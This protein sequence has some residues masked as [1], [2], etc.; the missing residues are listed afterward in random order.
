MGGVARGLRKGLVGLGFWLTVGIVGSSSAF[1]SDVVHVRFS[2]KLKGE[3]APLFVAQDQGY[4]TQSGLD[5]SLGEGA[6]AQ[7]ALGALLQGQEDV[8]V[9]PGIYALL[10][11]SRGMPIKLIA[12]YQPKAPI[13]YISYPA[14]P[15]LVPKDLEG[16]RIATSVGDTPTE[17]LEVLCKLNKI[18]CGTIKRIQVN[19]QARTAQFQA[20][21]VD[22]LG[23]YSN[24]DLPMIEKSLGKNF[25]QMDVTKYGLIVPGLAFVT[26]DRAIATKSDVLRRFLAATA[27]GF[28]YTAHDP[29]AAAKDLMSKWSAAPSDDVVIKQIQITNQATVIRPGYPLG[30]IDESNLKQALSILQQAGEITDAK[31]LDAYY[32]NALLSGTK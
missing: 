6:G 15:V 20:K 5:V 3:Y 21:D 4:Y 1:A 12:V 10:A 18:D 27:K 22:V 8:V 16:M 9:M 2:W 24:N 30:W 31:P 26:S 7:G 29:A 19:S 17:F 32:T 11:I 25:V 23:V 13:T 28:A 14:K